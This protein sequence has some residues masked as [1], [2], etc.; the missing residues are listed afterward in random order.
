MRLSGHGRWLTPGSLGT[1][2]LVLGG[3]AVMAGVTA[4]STASAET[5]GQVRVKRHPPLRVEV[6]PVGR[7]YRQCVDHPIVEHRPSGDTVVPAFACR[8]A[9]RP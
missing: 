7:L 8:W 3:L 4:A 1:L 2:A 6:A 9:V 5:T